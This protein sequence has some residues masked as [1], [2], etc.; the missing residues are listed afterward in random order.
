M[1]IHNV[2]VFDQ[3]ST[4]STIGGTL[5]YLEHELQIK[6]FISIAIIIIMISFMYSEHE[7]DFGNGNLIV[8]RPDL[9]LLALEIIESL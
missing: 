5:L 3:H 1:N 2:L 8:I 4:H 6:L 9:R 7:F